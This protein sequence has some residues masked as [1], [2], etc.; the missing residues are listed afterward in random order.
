[1]QLINKKRP[2]RPKASTPDIHKIASYNDFVKTQ[3]QDIQLLW[4]FLAHSRGLLC[5][6]NKYFLF[7]QFHVP[8]YLISVPRP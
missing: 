4:I 8:W 2:K 6:Y 5:P 7:I 3:V 1:M